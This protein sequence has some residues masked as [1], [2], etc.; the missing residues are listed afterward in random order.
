[1][2]FT[3]VSQPLATLLGAYCRHSAVALIFKLDP[4]LPLY[5][6]PLQ[7]TVMALRLVALL[8]A[9]CHHPAAVALILSF[10]C[11]LRCSSQPFPSH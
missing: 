3:A 4:P 9:D 6:C 1:M 5:K 10:K 11:F 8:G 2:Q 7:F